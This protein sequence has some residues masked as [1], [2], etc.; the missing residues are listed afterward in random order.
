MSEEPSFKNFADYFVMGLKVMGLK[1]NLCFKS[2]IIVW[3]DRLIEKT[4]YPL[5]WTLDLSTS[6]RQKEQDVISILN[7]VPGIQDTEISFRL[8]IAKLTLIKPV[9]YPYD[10]KFVTPEDSK[11]FSLLCFSVREYSDISNDIRGNIFQIYMDMDD[12]DQGYL[13]WS[14]F[15]KDYQ[16]LLSAGVNYQSFVKM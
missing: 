8:L 16:S 11:L 12:V 1:L 4:D 2:E 6:F 7:S 14:T 5:N 10:R 3:V 15:I 9:L 13:D